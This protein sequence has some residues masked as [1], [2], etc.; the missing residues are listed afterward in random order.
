MDCIQASKRLT[1]ARNSRDEADRT[2]LKPL[3]LLDS[4]DQDTRC[5]FEIGRKGMRNINY[6]V[7]GEESFGRFDDVNG[8]PIRRVLP[9][10][11]INS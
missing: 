8:R 5:A 4:I 10:C 7:T 3:R 1:S 11:G 9:R 2:M 6:G